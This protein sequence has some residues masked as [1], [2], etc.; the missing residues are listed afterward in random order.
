[1]GKMLEN[2]GLPLT[3]SVEAFL[4]H[5]EPVMSAVTHLM[6]K[7]E[8]FSGRIVEAIPLVTQIMDEAL[9]GLVDAHQQYRNG[10]QSEPKG[11]VAR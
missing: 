4:M 7:R 6:K 3:D 5:R 11:G 1:M 9:V 10:I 8:A 2:L